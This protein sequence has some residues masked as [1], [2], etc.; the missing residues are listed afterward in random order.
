MR[1]AVEQRDNYEY[2]ECKRQGKVQLKPTS[3]IIRRSKRR[4]W[5]A[6]KELEDYPELAIDDNNNVKLE[7]RKRDEPID[8]KNI[9]LLSMEEN[10]LCYLHTFLIIDEHKA[11]LNLANQNISLVKS[12]ENQISKIVTEKNVFFGF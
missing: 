4:M 9:Q 10:V 8:I 2:Q 1:A 6:I 11:V 5:I 7:A 3:T 12:R